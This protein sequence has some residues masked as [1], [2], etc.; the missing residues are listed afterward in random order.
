MCFCFPLKDPLEESLAAAAEIALLEHAQLATGDLNVGDVLWIV[1]VE[2][3]TLTEVI[4]SEFPMRFMCAVVAVKGE[5]A[6]LAV[7]QERAD[8]GNIQGARSDD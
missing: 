7:D 4:F 5:S 3:E 1:L 2:A 8:E 6:T